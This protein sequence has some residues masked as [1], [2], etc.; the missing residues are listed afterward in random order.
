MSNRQLDLHCH[1][2]A[3]DGSD[4]P[5]RLVRRAA[6]VGLRALA[7]TDHDTVSGLAEAE[8]EAARLGIELVR[9]CEIAVRHDEDELHLLGLFLPAELP[10]AFLDALKKER[11]RRRE[12]NAAMLE[13]LRELGLEISDD[14]LHR[15]AGGEVVGRPHMASVLLARQYVA[16]RSEAFERYLGR[17][18]TAFVPRGLLSPAEGIALLRE[19]GALAVLAHPC[20]SAGMTPERLHVCLSELADLG[21]DAV[22]AYHSTHNNAA[23]RLCLDCAATYGLGVSGGSD[24][25]GTA[26]AGI[27][28]GRAGDGMVIPSTLLDA[29]KAL[30][31]NRA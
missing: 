6:E 21:L 16:T 10:Q 14:E 7:L 1:S 2:S 9:G 22:E 30:H 23:V 27:Q 4:S 20:L 19:A 17:Y 5:T 31:R 15:A 24:Y 11:N 28:L 3:S 18:G 12:R 13:R 25:H 8:A 26:K 29:L